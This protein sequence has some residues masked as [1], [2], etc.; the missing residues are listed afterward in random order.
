MS[1]QNKRVAL[2][3]WMTFFAFFF[4][5]VPFNSILAAPKELPRVILA[6]HDSSPSQNIRWSPVH[7]IF[8]MPLNHLGFVVK[9]HN[10]SEP[11]PDIIDMDEVAGILI[12]F[13]NDSI[14]KPDVFL[15]WA[16][17]ASIAGKKLLLLGDHAFEK[18]ENGTY[19]D[20]KLLKKFWQRLG[21]VNRSDWNSVTYNS[22]AIYED[23]SIVGFERLLSGVLPP[24]P[25]IQAVGDDV[26]SHFVV[27]NGDDVK[28]ASHLITTGQGGGFIASGYTHFVGSKEEYLQWYINPFSFFRLAMDSDKLPKADT[29]TLSGRRIFYSHVDG[30][31]WRNLTEIPI[32]GEK[33]RLS[34]QV[35]YEEII[36][37]YS[38]LP[39]TVAPVAGDLDPDWFGSKESLNIAKKI[40]QSPNVE[41][42]SHTYSHP[43]DWA[44]F[45]DG[46]SKK[47]DP[48]IAR[49]PSPN[50]SLKGGLLQFFGLTKKVDVHYD[51]AIAKEKKL[52]LKNTNDDLASG[53]TI[54]RVYRRGDFSLEKEIAGSIEYIQSL[55][56]VG[57]KVELMQWSGDTMP[58]EKA[59]RL[60]REAGVENI[61]GGDSRFDREYPS[62]A[63]VA[64][65]GLQVGEELQVYASNS[66][67]NTYTDLWTD[68]FFGFQH[69]VRTLRNTE[70]PWRVKPINVYY[71]MYSGEKLSSLNALKKNLDY[72]QS[73]NITPITTSQFSAIVKGF[74]SCK[75]T[76][77][78]DNRWQLEG[79][80]DL[81]TIRFDFSTFK[82]VDIESS[83][84]VVGQK[85]YH[86][87]LYVALD[88]SIKDPVIALVDIEHGD[89][90]PAI[91]KPYLID[92]CWQVWNVQRVA[93]KTKF[94]TGGF[95]VGDMRWRIPKG[96]SC[97]VWKTDGEKISA[98]E[99]NNQLIFKIAARK[100]PEDI[101][102]ITIDCHGDIQ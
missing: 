82:G 60:S 19:T 1:S 23:R 76:A 92:S 42:A 13:E 59:L 52:A 78:T 18:A 61:N 84:G 29:T 12:W 38:H 2:I 50:S 70:T 73:H 80:G 65:L 67:E 93:G 102:D 14:P 77:L 90:P 62:F 74:Y 63:W 75:I 44:F 43:L 31:G 91:E 53:Y 27:Q 21:L 40:F 95:G 58:F 94:S 56:P 99:Q 33:K 28:S 81:Q 66:N 71:H 68:R 85:H 10:I 11:L 24:Y 89:G 51:S 5:L 54:P 3:F 6:I 4:V 34:S 8:Q 35:I 97:Q 96:R 37:G 49:Y 30:D 86:G 100:K 79:C 26:T 9:F 98:K 25:T 32:K 36:K 20:E 47:E 72:A 15:R 46:N 101:V 69:L 88:K 64:P 55:L 48:F 17:N 39:V 16:I 22:K 45:K 87:S 83:V 57:K 41:A 7:R